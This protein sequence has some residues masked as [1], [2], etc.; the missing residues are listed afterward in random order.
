MR[1]RRKRSDTATSRVA[2][3][4]AL[5]KKLL[6]PKDVVLP[7]DA[8][9]R[10][11]RVVRARARETWT[12]IDLEHAANLACCLADLERLRAEVR[13]EG[14]T[15]EN[16]R[17]TQVMNPKHTLMEVLSRRAVALSRLLHVHA[18]A[19]QGRSRDTGQKTKEEKRAAEALEIVDADDLIAPPIH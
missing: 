1:Q 15:I 19:T 4:Q 18:D 12:E 17:G 14:D 9:V 13:D 5:S 16:K 3:V 7:P 8:E 2:A 11:N 10:F 6:P